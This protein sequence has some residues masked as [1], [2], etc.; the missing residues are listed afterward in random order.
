[1]RAIVIKDFYSKTNT[2]I[3]EGKK[4]QHL[5]HV[6][7]VRLDE[8]VCVLDGAG[9]S[10][11]TKIINIKKKSLELEILEKNKSEREDLNISVSFGLTKKE[12]FELSIKQFIEI[13]IRNITVLKTEFSQRYDVKEDRLISI[14]ESAMEQSN[15]ANYPIIKFQNF[16]DFVK[17]EKNEIIYFSSIGT[18]NKELDVSNNKKYNLLFGPEGGLS[19]KEE[20]KIIEIDSTVIHLPTNI[21]RTSTAVNFCSGYILGKLGL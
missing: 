13:G 2:F 14:I 19:T 8:E 3:L 20:N 5:L 10:Y 4:A 1:M 7:R 16:D 17:E 11:L 21:M 18:K 9:Y 12:S 15:E 6:A